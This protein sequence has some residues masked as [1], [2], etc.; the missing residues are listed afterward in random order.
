MQSGEAVVNN[1]VNNVVIFSS[2]AVNNLQWI[3]YDGLIVKIHIIIMTYSLQVIHCT[4]REIHDIIHDIIHDMI[5]AYHEVIHDSFHRWVFT[6]F[7][8]PLSEGFPPTAFI[9]ITRFPRPLSEVFH[10]LPLLH[11]TLY[12]PM[13]PTD[14]WGIVCPMG[15]F[16]WFCRTRCAC[17]YCWTWRRALW[18]SLVAL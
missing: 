8:H 1:V 2:G 5:P 9:V 6:S 18:L 4:T 11:R 3:S 13:D 16:M 15:C 7:S 17:T 12:A 14:H 10:R